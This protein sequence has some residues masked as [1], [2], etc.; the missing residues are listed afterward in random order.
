VS[1][2]PAGNGARET[3]KREIEMW[4]WRKVRRGYWVCETANKQMD[5]FSLGLTAAFVPEGSDRKWLYGWHL[6]RR[7]SDGW[8]IAHLGCF[9]KRKLAIA[10]LDAL[11]AEQAALNAELG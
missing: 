1:E 8:I 10:H 3:Q 6:K 4:N 11:I 2:R 9:E 5:Y 7:R